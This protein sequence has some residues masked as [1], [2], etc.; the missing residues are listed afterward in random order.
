MRIMPNIF[1]IGTSNSA[2]LKE[3]PLSVDVDSITS[4]IE[5]LGMSW[6]YLIC[7]LWYEFSLS[8]GPTR[9]GF[10]LPNKK[11][12]LYGNGTTRVNLTT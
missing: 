6:T 1:S 8:M 9:F 12:T 5:A 4:E 7:N 11:P 10:D 3:A 2:L